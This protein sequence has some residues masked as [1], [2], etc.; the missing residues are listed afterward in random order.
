MTL[1]SAS[2]RP[3]AGRAL[4]YGLGSVGTGV[5]ST[6]PSVLLL[7]YCTEV[8]GVAPGVAG[9]ILFAPKL[10]SLA[11]DPLV[12][13]WSDRTRSRW[14][15]RAPFLVTGALGVAAAFAALFAAPFGAGTLAAAWIAGAY[16]VLATV[17]SVYAVPYVAAPAEEPDAAA[18]GRLIAWRMTLVMAGVMLGAAGAPL[19][20]EAFGG[21]LAGYRAMGLV[22]G[23]AC[24]VLMLAPV[25]V[26]R[27]SA[28][29]ATPGGAIA[30]RAARQGPYAWLALS[31]VGQ[32]AGVAVVSATMPYLVTRG[33]GRATGD[34]GVAM[35]VVLASTLLAVPAWSLAAGRMGAARA[36]RLA[37]GVYGVAA[38]TPMAVL[39][40]RPGWEAFLGALGLLG[41]GFAGLQVLPFILCARVIAAAAPSAEGALTGIWTASEKVGLAIGPALTAAALALL[42]RAHGADLVIF[43]G[44]APATLAALSLV[45]LALS[46]V[47]P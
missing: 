46:K 13:V 30:W 36:L 10:W 11:W 45:P 37:V 26:L 23:L 12:G 22:V 28:G 40:T 24:L 35:A 31:Y 15:R 47:G 18:A 32:M 19:M 34:V 25:A 8:A 20:V 2:P 41:V 42:P 1:A 39:L 3:S 14:G 44:L 21:G 6:T 27:R 4:A 5:F 43:A 29:P 16:F 33:L 17:Y 7:F 9:L 38:L